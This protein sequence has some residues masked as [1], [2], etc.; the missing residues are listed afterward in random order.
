MSFAVVSAC[1]AAALGVWLARRRK[2]RADGPW[3]VLGVCA[4]CG[5]SVPR[6]FFLDKGT[7][8][9]PYSLHRYP[10]PD[11]CRVCRHQKGFPPVPWNPG[12]TEA[13]YDA[14]SDAIFSV[15]ARPARPS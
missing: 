12:E 6:W 7:A 2:R 10:I 11:R 3:R 13:A 8:R 5:Q 15:R 14:R 1:L 4:G 9:G